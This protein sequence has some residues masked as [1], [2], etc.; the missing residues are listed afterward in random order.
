MFR[1]YVY[2]LVPIFIIALAVQVY[3]GFWDDSIDFDKGAVAAGWTTNVPNEYKKVSSCYMA[4]K[5]IASGN[6]ETDQGHHTSS[7]WVGKPNKIYVKD[8]A[9][10]E[11]NG[12]VRFQST[13]G[14]ITKN[15]DMYDPLSTRTTGGAPATGVHRV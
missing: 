14:Q 9:K 11:G 15:G 6:C 8:F 1:K 10:Y 3:A 13:G 2:F 5:H 7:N 12:Y 4:H